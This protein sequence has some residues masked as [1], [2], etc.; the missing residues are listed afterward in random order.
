MQDPSETIQHEF[1]K[2]IFLF[3]HVIIINLSKCQITS[4]TNYFAYCNNN[5]VLS[6]DLRINA[7]EDFMNYGNYN[8]LRRTANLKQ[9]SREV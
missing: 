3:R 8:Q 9:N 2:L 1:N 4:L 7:I 6:T 5:I